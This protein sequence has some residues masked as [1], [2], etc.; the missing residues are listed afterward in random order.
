VICF[1]LDPLRIGYCFYEFFSIKNVYFSIRALGLWW[2]LK[3]RKRQLSLLIKGILNLNSIRHGRSSGM[4]M[5]KYNCRYLRRSKLSMLFAIPRIRIYSSEKEL[6]M[7][8]RL[9]R[10]LSRSLW[11]WL[12]IYIMI[13]IIKLQGRHI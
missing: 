8:C 11:M 5:W 10:K 6:S 13:L 4:L 7:L 3:V 2:C 12:S 9:S 1:E